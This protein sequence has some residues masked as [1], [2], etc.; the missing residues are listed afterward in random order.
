MVER[1]GVHPEAAHGSRP[2]PLDGVRH[3]PAANAAPHQLA[4]EAEEGEFAIARGAKIELC[5]PLVPTVTDDT[6]DLDIG[7]ADDG[8]E[9]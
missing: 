9:G 3:E 1:A 2:G 7:A 8:L 4:R 5:Q 6:P